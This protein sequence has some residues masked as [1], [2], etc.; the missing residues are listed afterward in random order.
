MMG[1]EIGVK[2]EPKVGSTFWFTLKLQRAP[3]AEGKARASRVDL[4][5]LRVLIVD[6]N[7]TNR[8][9]LRRQL[10]SWKMMDGIAEDGPVP[11]EMLLDT[12]DSDEPY[13][14]AILDMQMPEMD[15]VELAR[16]IKADPVI[17][18]TRLM[19]LTSMGL[20]VNEEA[21]RAGV[22][23]IL[24]KP[25]RQS[26]LHDAL[27]TTIGTPT[28]APTPRSSREAPCQPSANPPWW[29]SNHHSAATSSWPKITRLI[30]ALQ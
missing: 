16:A 27:A 21:R 5:D 19:L 29:T 30:N 17:A 11:L 22:D 3:E 8:E 7:S 20:D 14:L 1:G 13:D 15:G 6:D 9:I 12:A 26:Q 24:S 18:S 10:T 2:S 25:V 4:G 23:T 28:E